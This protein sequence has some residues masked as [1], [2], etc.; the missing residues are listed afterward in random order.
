MRSAPYANFWGN[1]A[2]PYWELNVQ[3]KYGV[4][5]VSAAAREGSASSMTAIG[6]RSLWRMYKTLAPSHAWRQVNLD[7]IA[8]C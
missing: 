5:N 3:P 7:G 2:S 6:H 8:V 4:R 1:S